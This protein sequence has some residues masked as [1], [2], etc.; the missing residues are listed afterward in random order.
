MAAAVTVGRAVVVVAVAA[1]GGGAG[2]A[3]EVR[4]GGGSGTV[5]F[6]CRGRDKQ[7]G[8]AGRSDERRQDSG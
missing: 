4:G 6:I 2:S 1:E 5:A 8:P 7:Y 3:A